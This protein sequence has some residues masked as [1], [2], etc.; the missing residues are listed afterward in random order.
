MGL[1]LLFPP[2]V[3]WALGAHGMSWVMKHHPMGVLEKTWVSPHT[4]HVTFLSPSPYPMPWRPPDLTLWK[5][6]EPPDVPTESQWVVSKWSPQ[7]TL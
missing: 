4:A 2:L 6:L 3:S 7:T 5:H 1:N